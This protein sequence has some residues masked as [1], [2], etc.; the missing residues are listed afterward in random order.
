MAALS[1]M[2]LA[3]TYDPTCMA[4]SVDVPSKQGLR[5]SKLGLTNHAAETLGIDT[6]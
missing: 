4:S 2:L 1:G 5:C 3:A 6:P